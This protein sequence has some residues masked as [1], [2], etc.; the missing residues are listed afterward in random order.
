[1]A[2][3]CDEW[4]LGFDSQLYLTAHERYV[5]QPDWAIEPVEYECLECSK[6]FSK[7]R[8]MMFHRKKKHGQKETE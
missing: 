2:F 5:H 8:N 6:T 3:V 7:Y 1:M 4:S